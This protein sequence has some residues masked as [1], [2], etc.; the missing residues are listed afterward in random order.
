MTAHALPRPDG[1][2]LAGG[3]GTR[4]KQAVAAGLASGAGP[5][6]AVR[7]PTGQAQG[8]PVTL[9]KAWHLLD[10]V[11]LV[12]HAAGRLRPQVSRLLISS[13]DH[14]DRYA[15]L[16]CPVSDACTQRLGPLAGILAALEATQADWLAVAP[17]D[18][19]FLPD[20]WVARLQQAACMQ[21]AP[22]ALAM[23]GGF[24][25]PVCMV[26]R[27]DQR[28]RLGQ[29]LDEGVRKVGQWQRAIGA[30]TVGFDDAPAHAFMNINTLADLA[31]AEDLVRRHH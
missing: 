9:D 29:L 3:L 5:G 10:G 27:R 16:G 14:P 6:K 2:I 15:D 7:P 18:S 25:Q 17:C 4:M 24:R 19:P 31:Q 8:K 23:H 13:H 30:V 22:L 12:V 11:P 1:V 20:G 21:Q 26:V 28:E